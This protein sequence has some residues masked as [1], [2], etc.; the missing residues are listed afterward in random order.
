MDFLKKI[1]SDFRIADRTLVLDFKNAFKIAEKYHAEALCAE[2]TSFNFAECKNWRR[3]RDLNPRY[4][5]VY[6]LSKRAHSAAMRPLRN[7]K[8]KARSTKSQTNSKIK[9]QNQNKIKK[10]KRAAYLRNGY[11][12]NKKCHKINQRM[13]RLA[14][15]SIGP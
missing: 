4:L 14:M 15:V 3:G 7:I 5:S 6:A 9:I 11:T 8:F 10:N 2:A 1:G 13:A 12:I